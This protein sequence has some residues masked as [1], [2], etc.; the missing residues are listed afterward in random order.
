MYKDGLYPVYIVL[1]QTCKG[2][3]GSGGVF[4]PLS[5]CRTLS[6]SDQEK[7]RRIAHTHHLNC[8]A[9][10]RPRRTLSQIPTLIITPVYYDYYDY[11]MMEM[12][13]MEPAPEK[14]P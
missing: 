6:V 12:P 10:T 13:A 3:R 8:A 4:I 1:G 2:R 14:M 7:N 9:L 5:P 11:G